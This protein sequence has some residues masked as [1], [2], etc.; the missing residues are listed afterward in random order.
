MT[1]RV[2]E[3]LSGAERYLSDA[4]VPPVVW[5]AWRSIQECRTAA[6]GGHAVVCPRGHVEGVW[7]NAC[8]NR[9]CPR[10]ASYRV[11]LW[12]ERQARTLLGCAHHH[13]IFTIPHELNVLWLLNYRELGEL[14]FK[15]ARDALFELASDSR[16]LG[17]TPGVIAAL[18]TWGQQLYLH[19]HVH[20]LVTDGGV[21]EEGRWIR[22]PRKSL[23]PAEPLKRLFRGKFLYGLRGLAFRGELRLPDGW[24]KSD[25][26]KLC[27][28]VEDKRWNVYV[29]E[30][31]S[32]PT[33]V[34]NYLGR[35]LHGGPMGEGRLVAFDSDSVTFRY[36]DYR[37]I[38]PEG[39]R[40]KHMTLSRLEFIHRYLQHVAPKGFHLVRGYGPY[41]RGGNTEALRRSVRDAL[42]LTPQLHRSLGPRELPPPEETDG[43]QSCS[44]CGGPLTLIS[45]RARAGP[46]RMA[47]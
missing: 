1:I 38:G 45:R 15:S 34:L 26:L 8:R 30:R 29:C 32:D 25:V 7:Y 16:Y 31:Y 46:F 10:C 44:I 23:L 36:K 22:S 43:M 14:L 2:A 17:A 24:G 42:P 3:I 33:A 6:L 4:G 9:A 27:R 41:R 12:L 35:Y 40:Q 21:D 28:K 18:H 19:P 13:I 47:A 39:P 11:R 20:C 37:D 5:R